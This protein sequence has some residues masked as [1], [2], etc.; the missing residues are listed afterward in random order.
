MSNNFLDI[1]YI[2]NKDLQNVVDLSTYPVCGRIIKEK[3]PMNLLSNLKNY[4]KN[5]LCTYANN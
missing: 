1:Q 4:T 3:A 5:Y 2:E